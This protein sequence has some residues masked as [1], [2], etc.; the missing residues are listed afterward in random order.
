M[1]AYPL[2]SITVDE[3]MKKQFELVDI[4]CENFEG[5]ESL[6]LGDLGVEKENNM[7]KKTRKIEKILAQFFKSEDAMLVRG[8]GTNAL[9]MSLYV[10]LEKENKILVHNA[11]IY[12]TTKVNLDAMKVEILKYD[13]NNL[14]N[15]EKY[16]LDN[17]INVVLLQHTRQ[18]LEDSYNLEEVIKKLKDIRPNIKILVD[19]NYA[20]LK[21]PKNSIEMGT[22]LSAFSMFKLLGPVG[23]GL[24]L[25][26][27]ELISR[28]RKLNYSGGSQVQGY[29]AVKVLRGLIYAPVSLAIQ[30][31]QIEKLKEILDDNKKFPYIKETIIANAQ[32][33]VLLVEFKEN[34]AKKI[35]K[36]SCKLGALPNPVGAESEFDLMPLIYRVSGTF[37]E[38]DNTLIDRMIRINPN[39]S[40]AKTIA[41]II[42]NSYYMREE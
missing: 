19:D 18:K 21:T 27:N 42:E 1:K 13:F 15:L 17:D 26:T 14:E 29:E 2:K 8:A 31:K 39:R 6:D 10:L 30:A 40:G 23:V 3:A 28:I 5:F 4:I 35:I 34:I 9:R 22:D 25:G 38:N 7:P 33:K 12:K 24:I 11:P 36:N 41:K 32:S 37:L 20:V 16:I